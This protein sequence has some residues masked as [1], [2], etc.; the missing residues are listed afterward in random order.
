MAGLER[1]LFTFYS[2]PDVNSNTLSLPFS[3]FPSKLIAID[4]HT[5]VM[6]I[7]SPGFSNHIVFFQYLKYL[8]VSSIR[9]ISDHG[10]KQ[11]AE[12]G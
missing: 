6:G 12:K 7:I 4:S 8:L 3:P 1:Q 2:F 10:K 11:E 9:S 5:P